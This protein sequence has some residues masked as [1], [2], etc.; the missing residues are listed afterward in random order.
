MS[1]NLPVIN[2]TITIIFEVDSIPSIPGKIRYKPTQKAPT[3]CISISGFD[4]N[5]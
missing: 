2:P 3:K 4:L 5:K 1:R